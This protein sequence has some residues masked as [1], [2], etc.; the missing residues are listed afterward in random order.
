M[1]CTA[2][3]ERGTIINNN[4]HPD[5]KEEMEPIVSRDVNSKGGSLLD[6]EGDEYIDEPR[7]SQ[8]L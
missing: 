1:V 6:E 3:P 5:S 4:L 2:D 7:R 8:R